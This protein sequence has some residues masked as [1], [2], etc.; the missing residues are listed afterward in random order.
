MSEGRSSVSKASSYREMGEYWDDYDLDDAWDPS[1]RVEFDV[2]IQSR[3]R[4]FPIDRELS[5]KIDDA[6]RRRGVT[7]ETLLNLWVQ[8]KVAQAG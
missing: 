4:Y 6:A 8:E 2:D 1:R 3:L 7:A 5:R